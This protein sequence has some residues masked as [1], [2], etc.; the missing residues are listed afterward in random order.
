MA[1]LCDSEFGPL[2]TVV[3]DGSASA[4][5]AAVESSCGPEEA[6]DVRSCRR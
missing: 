5:R 3:I 1:N 4:P 2:I 6:A